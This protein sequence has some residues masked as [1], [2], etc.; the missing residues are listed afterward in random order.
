M[1]YG[2]YISLQNSCKKLPEKVQYYAFG[3]LYKLTHNQHG[4]AQV[5]NSL[6]LGLLGRTLIFITA[7]LQKL[8]R[9]TNTD[10]RYS[11]AQLAQ[12]H[13]LPAVNFL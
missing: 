11:S 9:I 1:P 6:F 2:K 12:S 8:I 3:G 4:F 10:G 5:G 7:N 13:V